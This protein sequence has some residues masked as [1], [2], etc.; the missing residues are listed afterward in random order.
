[1]FF[2]HCNKNRQKSIVYYLKVR[3]EEISRLPIVSQRL[4]LLGDDIYDYE[5]IS[6]F[7]TLS[8]SPIILIPIS[9]SSGS[10]IIN[11]NSPELRESLPIVMN[12]RSSFLIEDIK[13]MVQDKTGY[14][15]E[16]LDVF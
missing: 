1:M 6:S 14:P 16:D 8:D 9:Y 12:L 10:F 4:L 2:S 3:I 11:T 7:K 15:P 5:L 13:Y